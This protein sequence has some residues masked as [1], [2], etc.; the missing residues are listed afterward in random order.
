M[1]RSMPDATAQTRT[2]P[3]SAATRVQAAS[4]PLVAETQPMP[5]F[6]ATETQPSPPIIPM[7]SFM[8][9]AAA[10]TGSA[11][12][13]TA[14]QTQAAL[15]PLAADAQPVPMPSSPTTQT[16]TGSAPDSAATQ[17]HGS[18]H[19]LAAETQPTPT[20]P[21]TQTQ[22]ASAS[23]VHYQLKWILD[24]A[25]QS[26]PLCMQNRNGPCPL[27]ALIN[28]SLLRGD[29]SITPG[30]TRI[31]EDH[32]MTL[33]AEYVSSRPA[34]SNLPSEEAQAVRQHAVNDFLDLLPC[35]NTGMMVN[36]RFSGP[37]DFEFTRELSVFDVFPNLRL[38][39][40]WLVDPQDTR[41]MVTLGN[42]SYNQVL[43]ELVRTAESYS[44]DGEA[45][46]PS[47]P[48]PEAFETEESTLPAE[49][50]QITAEE[51]SATMNIRELRPL[52]IDFLESNSTQLTVYGLT[53]LH[54]A[55]REDEIAILFR[56]SHFYVIRKHQSEIY[57]LV[58]DEGFL[59]ELNTVWEKL[60]DVNGDST[61]YNAAFQRITATG[62]VVGRA[63]APPRTRPSQMG[64][65]PDAN[66]SG[67]QRLS[68]RPGGSRK[69][70]YGTSTG[71]S[72]GAGV[73]SSMNSANRRKKASKC[74]IQ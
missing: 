4:D 37:M 74:I 63:S 49:E 48:P 11:P 18:P 61:F 23:V 64:T 25:G 17:T 56:N 31:R 20:S 53:E 45:A 43:D 33:L 12:Y 65:R 67:S 13:S 60:T 62:E 68:S 5:S 70:T 52:V 22:N 30:T 10:Q 19:P 41:L 35:L 3:D 8:P 14:P 58:T 44:H 21:T 1:S 42:L 55:L 24:S 51:S 9:D 7:S 69:A 27:I 50:C 57:T 32:L 36:P 26:I 47:A 40:G 73:A 46:A 28:A 54:S 39:H 16:Q 34:P 59:R 6:P 72:S 66:P 29:I 15:H 71:N 2:A 38:V